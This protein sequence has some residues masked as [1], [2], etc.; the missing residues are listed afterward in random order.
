[1]LFVSHRYGG[2]SEIHVED[3]ARRLAREDCHV[4][5]LEAN[6]DNRGTVTIRNLT[7]GTRSVYALPRDAEALLADLRACGIWHIHFHQIMGGERWARLPEE[8]GC[9]YDVT[10][11]DYSYFCPRIDLIDERRQYCGEPAVEICERCIALNRPHPQLQDAFRDHGGLSQWLRL[12]GALLS[13]ARRVFAP[14]HDV[15]ARMQRH[16]S[17]VEY[18][19]RYHLEPARSV[20]IRRPASNGAVRVAVIG[21]I[22][23]NKGYDLLL[24]CARD[25]LKQGLRIEFNLFGYSEDETPL[26]QLA[27][28]R[29]LGEYAREDLPR[30]VAENPCD[31]ALFLSIWPETYCYALS[32]AYALGLY[33]IAL[34]FG[35]LE[36]RI[37]ASG[38]GALLPAASTPAKINAA[39][40]A[41]L[42]RA[43]TWP[44]AVTTG[45]ESD[46]ILADYYGLRAR[47]MAPSRIAARRN[48]SKQVGSGLR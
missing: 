37:A 15:A 41:E 1:M 12:H 8:L 34:G 11:H 31:V 32:D 44:E 20:M 5:I 18:T 38:V 47:D 22:G 28:V 16:M 24:G 7:I 2:G 45:E 30:L 6:N 23:P 19:V 42:A 33:P 4:L 10:V 40:L 35:A 9:S 39:I 27:N 21:A 43:D 36:E 25:A 13:G 46:D 3:M 26:R 48:K 29:L 14:S 17:G